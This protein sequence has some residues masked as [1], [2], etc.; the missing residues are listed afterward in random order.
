MKRHFLF[1]TAVFFT[2][3][4]KAQHNIRA[5]MPGAFD[6]EYPSALGIQL[7]FGEDEYN[8]NIYTNIHLNPHR[9]VAAIY[10]YQHSWDSL[11]TK[12]NS[13]Q[14]QEGELGYGH[15]ENYGRFYT[16]SI[17]YVGLQQYS[18][19][20]YDTALRIQSYGTKSITATFEYQAGIRFEYWTLTV[21]NRFKGMYALGSLEAPNHSNTRAMAALNSSK[22]AMSTIIY[23]P[24]LMLG[25]LCNYDSYITLS[26][27][28]RFQGNGTA[29]FTYA[30]SWN[31]AL[32]AFLSF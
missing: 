7:G 20:Y 1:L 14:L 27:Q 18:Y 13:W 32:G 17:G 11:D 15:T 30:N 5:V 6:E 28:T 23:E 26:A 12:H 21:T 29:N 19:R 16:Q 8:F 31:C 22:T 4:A 24:G 10:S 25:L 3:T 2:I 9:S